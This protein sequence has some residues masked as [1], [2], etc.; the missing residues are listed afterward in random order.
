MSI[1]FIMSEN[2]SLI[3]VRI[4]L[5]FLIDDVSNSGS[6]SQLPRT[7]TWWIMFLWFSM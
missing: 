7:F 5:N 6:K 1:F 2:L 3:V 4:W